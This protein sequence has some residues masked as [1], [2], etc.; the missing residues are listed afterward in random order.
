MNSYITIINESAKIKGELDKLGVKQIAITTGSIKD[1]AHWYNCSK[2]KG[3]VLVD[4]SG[5]MP[6]LFSM[7]KRKSTKANLFSAKMM[8]IRSKS[9]NFTSGEPF[10]VKPSKDKKN[11]DWHFKLFVL[12]G[13]R[14][15]FESKFRGEPQ[16][17]LNLLQA[18][19]ASLETIATSKKRLKK[20]K[21]LS[22]F[23]SLR[24]SSVKSFNLK[25]NNG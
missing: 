6:Q 4:T 17:L 7:Q 16:D 5:K 23:F 20:K 15:S 22:A 25:N 3:E 2:F 18:C 14:I 13:D 9:H 12:Y 8:K 1:S 10:K 24:R 11:E 21:R 19:G